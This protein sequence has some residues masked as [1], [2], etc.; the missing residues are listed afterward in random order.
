MHIPSITSASSNVAISINEE[1][2][3]C[4]LCEEFRCNVA[5]VKFGYMRLAEEYQKTPNFIIVLN[6][7]DFT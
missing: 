6:V 7:L 5:N 2:W 4:S 1:E 3:F